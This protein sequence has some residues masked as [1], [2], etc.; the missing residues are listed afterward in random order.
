MTEE[1][2]QHSLIT[3]FG[4]GMRGFCEHPADLR[5]A[6]L[7]LGDLISSG[8]GWEELKPIVE[9]I[10]ASIPDRDSVA[11]MEKVKRFIGPWILD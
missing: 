5:E 3:C 11:Q 1:E 8:V 6:H 10:V 7:F 2:I 9:T 4:R